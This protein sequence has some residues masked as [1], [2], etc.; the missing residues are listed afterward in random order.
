M[1]PKTNLTFQELQTAL[2]ADG[3]PSAI[4]VDATANKVFIDVSVLTGENITS[5]SQSGVVEALYKLRKGAG[6]AQETVNEGQ[7]D[8]ERLAAFPASSFGAP[9]D[10]F[11]STTLVSTY[12]IP[13]NE[14]TVNGPTQ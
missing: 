2:E 7:I 1:A 13:L 14:Q 11:V 10:G 12:L 6:A 5:L 3:L 8:G 9:V 4:V